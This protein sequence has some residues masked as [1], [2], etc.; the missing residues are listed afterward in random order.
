MEQISVLIA[1]DHE[2]V[3]Y[4]L[5]TLLES[6]ADIA[7]AGEAADTQSVIDECTKLRPDVVLLDLRMPGAGGVEACRSILQASPESRVLVLTSFDDDDEVFGVLSAGASGYILKGTRPERIVRA[8]RA[9]ADGQSVFDSNVATRII[10]GRT[11]K[12]AEGETDSLSERELQVLQLMAKGMSNKDIGRALW[13]GET[14]VKTHVSHI[15]RKLRQADRT[16]AVLVAVKAG[17]IGLK[18]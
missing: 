7:V 2:L 12:G 13:I 11:Q 17:I 5:R 16:Q 9:V 8:I 15:L 10:S 6:E 4:A 3:R 14:T 1:D 18:Q